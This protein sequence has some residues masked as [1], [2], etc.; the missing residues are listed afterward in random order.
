MDLGMRRLRRM[1][2]PG[3][4]EDGMRTIKKKGK[5][6]KCGYPFEVGKDGTA[7]TLREHCP[8]LNAPRRMICQVP[9]CRYQS[10]RTKRLE[11]GDVRRR[12]RG[13]A[14]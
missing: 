13:P 14:I 8:V 10:G 9:T 1:E 3:R 2:S 6:A 12:A 4:R 7:I 5:C 11:A